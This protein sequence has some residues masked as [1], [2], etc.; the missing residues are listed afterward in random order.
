MR[1]EAAI[2]ECPHPSRS[3]RAQLSPATYRSEHM[4][5]PTSFFAGRGFRLFV[6]LRLAAKGLRRSPGTTFLAIAILSLG[7]ALPS[8]FF[9]LLVGAIR[10][11]PVPAGDR[12]VRVKVIQPER[13]GAPLLVLPGDL[14]SLGQV[15]SLES[16][17]GFRTFSG[18]IVDPGFAATRGQAG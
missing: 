1:G 13:S 4:S 7:L 11:I 14:V 10:P 12:V 6:A 18:T 15:E 5:F 8:T 17:G 3:R 9:S 2:G 16:L